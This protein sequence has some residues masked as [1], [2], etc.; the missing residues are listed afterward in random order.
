MRPVSLVAVGSS[1][2]AA[3]SLLCAAAWVAGATSLGLGPAFALFAAAIV[4]LAIGYGAWCKLEA[5][6][7]ERHRHHRIGQRR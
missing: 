7:A 1:L 3:L 4:A 2:I 5:L 6:E